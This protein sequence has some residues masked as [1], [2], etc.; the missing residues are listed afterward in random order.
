MPRSVGCS[1]RCSDSGVLGV[2]G[3][4]GTGSARWAGAAGSGVVSGSGATSRCGVGGG[5][6][7]V[8]SSGSPG[9]AL[10][11]LLGLALRGLGRAEQLRE[12]TLTHACALSRH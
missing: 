11:F 8:S 12:R 5:C 10:P 1:G 9:T 2:G 4:A 6:S 7:T 3:G